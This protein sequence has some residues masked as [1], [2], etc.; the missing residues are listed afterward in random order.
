MH[1]QQH[2]TQF[3]NETPPKKF[4]YAKKKKNVLVHNTRTLCFITPGIYCSVKLS[5]GPRKFSL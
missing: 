1:Q 3:K 5:R 2:Y 4:G